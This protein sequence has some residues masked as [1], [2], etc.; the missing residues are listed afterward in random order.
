MIHVGVREKDQVGTRHLFQRSAGSTRRFSPIVTGP[1]FR[2]TRALKTGSVRIVTPSI[3][4][5]T[6]LCPS[7][8]ACKPCVGPELGDAVC[9]GLRR[10]IVFARANSGPKVAGATRRA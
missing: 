2:P 5:S 1:K 6:V 4:R 7:Q 10:W 8:A 3:L 9:A